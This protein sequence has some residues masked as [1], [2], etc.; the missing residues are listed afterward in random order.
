MAPEADVNRTIG[1]VTAS[2]V[3][4][5][6]HPSFYSVGTLRIGAYSYTVDIN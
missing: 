4:D 2:E 1:L 5:L 3:R 6:A